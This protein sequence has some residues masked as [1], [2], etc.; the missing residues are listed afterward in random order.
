MKRKGVVVVALVLLFLS[1]ASE[2]PGNKSSVRIEAPERAAKGSEVT[3]RI[4]VFHE[5]NSFLHHTSWLYVKANGKE[6]ARWEFS[7]FSRPE[8]GDFIREITYKLEE[9]VEIV[10]E[11][12]CNMHGSAGPVTW[13]L[14]AE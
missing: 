9:G 5:G 8:A 1:L 13:T 6:I 4:Q 11:A 10:A 7:A 3:I 2:S 14:A 12:N